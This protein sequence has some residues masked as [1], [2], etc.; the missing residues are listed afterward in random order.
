MPTHFPCKLANKLYQAVLQGLLE[1]TPK[2][3]VLFI[4][5]DWNAKAG[6]QEIPRVTDKFGLEIQNERGQRLI[7][8]G[9]TN[10]FV[11]A[12][13]V[14]QQHKTFTHE[15]HWMINNEIKLILFFVTKDGVTLYS[16]QKQDWE[17]S[18]AQ[19][20]NSLLPNSE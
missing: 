9:Q 18:V 15:H 10:A 3:D 4:I 20:M 6:S 2:K 11:I 14:F 16:Q 12:N 13:T 1:L 17:L 5:G 19:I 7:K 8:F